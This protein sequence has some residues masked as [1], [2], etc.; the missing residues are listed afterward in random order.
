MRRMEIFCCGKIVA[1]RGGAKSDKNDKTKVTASV[2][3]APSA[4]WLAE[5]VALKLNRES[6]SL[7]TNSKPEW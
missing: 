1:G 2:L 4:N 7:C 5:P 6:P 3:P